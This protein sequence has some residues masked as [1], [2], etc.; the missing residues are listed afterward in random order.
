MNSDFGEFGLISAITRKSEI[1]KYSIGW[2]MYKPIDVVE[3]KGHGFYSRFYFYVKT[4]NSTN[5]VWLD[6][7]Q[8]RFN[9]EFEYADNEL[10]FSFHQYS[11]MNRLRLFTKLKN[12]FI[13]K[14]QSVQ[15][16]NDNKN[17]ISYSYSIRHKGITIPT[18]TIILGI[19]AF[20]VPNWSV[21]TF[22][23]EPGLPRGNLG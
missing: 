14:I 23:C 4:K 5:E 2:E 18:G 15:L 10:F 9:E 11:K 12:K 7:E 1:I 19:M 22:D 6:F 21:R 16:I 20:N 3:Y 8:R 17:D 13:L